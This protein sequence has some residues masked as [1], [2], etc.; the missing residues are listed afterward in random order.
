MQGHTEEIK[1][2]INQQNIVIQ[3]NIRSIWD[4]QKE[5]KK[6]KLLQ[7]VANENLNKNA[8]FLKREIE[9]KLDL[10][11]KHFNSSNERMEKTIV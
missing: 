5:M 9:D 2:E 7:D 1:E 3:R 10:I 11:D 4:L 6:H 8:S